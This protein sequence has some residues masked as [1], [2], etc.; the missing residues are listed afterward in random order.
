MLLT[1]TEYNPFL[2]KTQHTMSNSTR[3]L[4]PG[5]DEVKTVNVQPMT[6]RRTT[7]K[8]RDNTR[9]KMPKFIDDFK[10]E[11]LEICWSND[12]NI[13][14]IHE[15]IIQ[16]FRTKADREEALDKTISAFRLYKSSSLNAE[17]VS[18]IRSKIKKLENELKH[19]SS[20]SLMEYM[21]KV[22][23][24]ITTYKELSVSKPRV[25]GQKET[26]DY[27][28]QEKKADIV[29]Q[30]F[31]I[32]KEY[33]TMNIV[34]EQRSSG[35]CDKCGG[36]LSDDSEQYICTECYTIHK[37]IE[38]PIEIVEQ[39]D[40]YAIKSGYRRTIEDIILQFQNKFPINIPERVMD[41]IKKHIASYK[42][43]D[44][45]K[46]TKLDLYKVMK[47]KGLGTWYKHI[48]KIHHQLTGLAPPDISK[49]EQN[50][51]KR[52]ELLTEIYDDIKPDNRSN[53]M[54]KF[55]LLWLFLKNEGYDPHID[56]FI[57]LKGRDVEVNN[58]NIMK[59]GF[60]ILSERYPNMQWKIYEI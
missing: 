4:D 14:S 20:M 25:F 19:L 1:T 12:Y 36:I 3:I 24:L 31:N 47:A 27:F 58:I 17:D 29:E 23:S 21:T 57:M 40:T 2:K 9:N 11:P 48:N 45:K 26:I 38:N 52:G 13:P 41:I 15:K 56:D 8:C 16:F 10:V 33:Y 59:R 55:Y 5:N 7:R 43:F 35:L 46:M 34:R 32:A 37:K 6:T 42:N 50:V 49:Y 44:I 53:F 60:E 39:E 30:Y 51:I 18:E 28:N 54:H 22:K